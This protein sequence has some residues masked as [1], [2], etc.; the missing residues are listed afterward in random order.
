MIG[1]VSSQ[2]ATLG[3]VLSLSLACV[4]TVSA[5]DAPAS[6][7]QPLGWQYPWSC[8][9]SMDCKMV[10]DQGVRERP[11]GYVIGSTG[12]VVAYADKRV[13]DSPD[14]EYHWCAHQAGLDAGRT[15]C[16][17]VPPKGF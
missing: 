17:F 6:P 15:I 8:C 5:H 12:E 14:G 9:S 16:L 10:G 13:K 4:P 3:A 11:E 2:L 7:A 1:S